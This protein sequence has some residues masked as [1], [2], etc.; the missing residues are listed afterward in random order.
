MMKTFTV[1]FLALLASSAVLAQATDVECVKCIQQK[2]IDFGAVGTGR[3]QKQ[4]VTRDRIAPNAVGMTQIDPTEVQVRIGGECAAG[5]SVVAIAEDGSV[6]CGDAG[7]TLSADDELRVSQLEHDMDLVLEQVLACGDYKLYGCTQA[8]SADGTAF[9][10]NFFWGGIYNVASYTDPLAQD[11][12][13]G[14][15]FAIPTAGQADF[16]NLWIG[17]SANLTRNLFPETNEVLVD[18]CDNPTVQL[19]RTGEP[20]STRLVVNNGTYYRARQD[21]AGEYGPILDTVDVTGQ[22]YGLIN[23]QTPGNIVEAC[24]L[25]SDQT[26]LYDIYAIDMK[27]NI[28]DGRFDSL[29]THQ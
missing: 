10:R 24:T 15:F 27:F 16:G 26:G 12:G 4:S 9:E 29:W 2:D 5:Q 7:S 20:A 6:T 13:D 8:V 28:F 19:V 3:L 14:V 22:M 21:G 18:S 17:G 1:T 11:P 25:V 23:H